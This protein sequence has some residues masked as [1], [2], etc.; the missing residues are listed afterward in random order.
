MAEITSWSILLRISAGLNN[1]NT[2]WWICSCQGYRHF[3]W[4][5]EPLSYLPW[6]YFLSLQQT[7]D[8]FLVTCHVSYPQSFHVSIQTV[9]TQHPFL[10][11]D[12]KKNTIAWNRIRPERHKRNHQNLKSLIW[13][14]AVFPADS[15]HRAVQWKCWGINLVQLVVQL[16][17]FFLWLV[18]VL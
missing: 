16:M 4:S 6:F 13:K 10:G 15:L 1:F 11:R 9:Q 8:C 12:K 14:K 5:H 17:W 2:F 18:T 7:L 3:S